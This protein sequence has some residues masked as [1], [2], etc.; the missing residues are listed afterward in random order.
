MSYKKKPETEPKYEEYNLKEYEKLKK[1]NKQPDNVTKINTQK[2]NEQ[3]KVEEVKEEKKEQPQPKVVENTDLANEYLNMARVI[4]A[5]F[6]NYRKRSIVQLEKAKIDGIANAVEVLLPSLDAFKN[7]KEKIKDENTLQ[8]IDMLEKQILS[9]FEKLGVQ[10]IEAV[11]LPLDPNVHNVLAVAKD[12]TKPDGIILN[13]L[14]AGYKMQDKIIRC[15]QVV[16]NK[17]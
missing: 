2:Q 14:Q 7:A 11:G 13:E 6:D 8:G 3:P 15:S 5:D 9:G 17:L 10:K 16:V 12:E 4:Q 1:D